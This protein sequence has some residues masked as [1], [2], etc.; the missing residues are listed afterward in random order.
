MYSSH[1][2]ILRDQF[3]TVKLPFT[4][5][6]LSECEFCEYDV[7]HGIRV[8]LSRYSYHPVEEAEELIPVEE[9][10]LSVIIAILEAED[11]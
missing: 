7:P 8:N 5:S 11:E 10:D 3:S 9:N 1:W 6:F 4:V 2:Y